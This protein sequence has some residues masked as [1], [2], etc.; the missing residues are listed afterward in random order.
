V[1]TKKGWGGEENWGRNC[2]I[3]KCL[4]TKGLVFCYECD[5]YK[6]CE[7]FNKLFL[8]HLQYGENLREN[9]DKIRAGRAEEWLEEQDKKWRCPNCNKP[10]SMY[11]TECHWCGVELR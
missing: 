2:R 1:V 4:D 5:D 3:V 10:V 6:T 7:R 9:L 11:L 8:D